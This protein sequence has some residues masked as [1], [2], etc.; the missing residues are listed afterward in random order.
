MK[1][2]MVS[3]DFMT[4]FEVNCFIVLIDQ[5]IYKDIR[6]W[7][8]LTRILV[9][10]NEA[11]HSIPCRTNALFRFFSFDKRLECTD[12]GRFCLKILAPILS[13]AFDRRINHSYMRFCSI[14]CALLAHYNE[15]GAFF[16]DLMRDLAHGAAQINPCDYRT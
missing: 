16:L 9:S 14:R 3:N 11:H 5:L 7:G 1:I 6:N 12:L 10:A 8:E 4:V 15:S 2:A 13:A